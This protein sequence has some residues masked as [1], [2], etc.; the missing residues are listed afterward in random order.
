[1]RGDTYQT[2]FECFYKIEEVKELYKKESGYCK[3]APDAT[4]DTQKFT[5]VDV[6]T[7]KDCK[8]ACDEA[9]NKCWGF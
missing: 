2:E 7:V 4:L 6:T 3:L 8:V 1:M 5:G 9:V